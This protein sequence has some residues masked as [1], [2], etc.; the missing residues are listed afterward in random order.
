MTTELATG[1]T[2]ESVRPPLVAASARLEAEWR[3]AAECL[4]HSPPRSAERQRWAT[5]VRQLTDA[6]TCLESYASQL[7]GTLGR[8]DWAARR[9]G[10]YGVPAS[11]S[12]ASAGVGD[13]IR[14][15]DTLSPRIPSQYRHTL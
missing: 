3:A 4:T 6:L 15:Q 12:A 5:V 10:L 1:T 13:E 2:M 7:D 11:R 8:R 9:P 14:R